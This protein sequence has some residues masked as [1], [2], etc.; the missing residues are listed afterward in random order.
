MMRAVLRRLEGEGLAGRGLFSLHRYMKC[1]V[2]LCG[3]CA[4]DPGGLRVCSEGPVFRGDQLRGTEFGRY[5]RDASG[6]RKTIG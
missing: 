1:G 5:S 3:S 6:R 4:I 2:G